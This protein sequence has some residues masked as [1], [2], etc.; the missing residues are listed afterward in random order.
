VRIRFAPEPCCLHVRKFVGEKGQACAG[1]RATNKRRRL[2]PRRPPTTLGAKETASAREPQGLI[3]RDHD[4]SARSKYELL[5]YRGYMPPADQAVPD[6]F[7]SPVGEFLHG[8]GRN[9]VENPFMSSTPPRGAN[10]KRFVS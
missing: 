2:T 6:L 7:I 4:A 5:P 10:A 8:P 1:R 3:L 9:A